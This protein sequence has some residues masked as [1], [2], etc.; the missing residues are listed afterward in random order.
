MSEQV[1]NTPLHALLTLKCLGGIWVENKQEE[2][3]NKWY[4]FSRSEAPKVPG[5]LDQCHALLLGTQR[6][7]FQ[8]WFSA[9]LRVP[10]PKAPRVGAWSSSRSTR[11]S[12][13]TSWKE[14]GVKLGG[15]FS[16]SACWGFFADQGYSRIDFILELHGLRAYGVLELEGINH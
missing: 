15:R 9:W 10:H 1:K 13:G 7:R 16:D 4:W 11:H 12:K 5:H 3:Q 14:W 2:S 6:T 8:R